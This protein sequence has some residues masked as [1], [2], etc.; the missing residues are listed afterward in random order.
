MPNVKKLIGI[1]MTVAGS[2]V[3]V[4]GL[5][6][7]ITFLLARIVVGNEYNR[8]MEELDDFVMHSEAVMGTVQSVES[9]EDPETT[10][11]YKVDGE[12][13]YVTLTVA[14]SRYRVS[15]TVRV[16]Y[17]SAD[18]SVCVVPDL[19]GN[20]LMPAMVALVVGIV[21][22]VVVGVVGLGILIGG[23][24]LIKKSKIPV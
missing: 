15:D 7:F 5:S 14:D 6:L 2:C 22:G 13:Y 24:V 1:L 17:D 20:V 10:I 18:P 23:I 11:K 12:S 3:L 19:Y 16:Y 4:V 8:Q 21:I 9:G